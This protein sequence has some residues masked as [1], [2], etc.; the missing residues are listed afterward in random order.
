MTWTKHG[1]QKE[2]VL[3]LDKAAEKT[4]IPIEQIREISGALTIQGKDE[5]QNA[6]TVN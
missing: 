6:Q 4:H 2:K 3:G 1:S 5:P